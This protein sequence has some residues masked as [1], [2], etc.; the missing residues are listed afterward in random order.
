MKINFL[1]LLLFSHFFGFSQNYFIY[2]SDKPA[3]D[4]TLIINNLSQKSLERRA[5]KNIKLNESDFPINQ[6]YLD[7]L[8]EL[9][10]KP[11]NQSKWL[12]GVL[13]K[14]SDTNLVNQL[15]NKSYVKSIHNLQKTALAGGITEWTS[16][17]YGQNWKST[18]FLGVEKLHQQNLLGSGILIAIFDAGFVSVNSASAFGHLYT[19]NLLKDVYNFNNSTAEIYQSSNHGTRVLSLINSK[20]ENS[21]IGT[22]P[23]SE[24]ALYVTENINSET[25]LEEYQWLF[26]AERADSLG[27]DIINSS[28]GYYDFDFPSTNHTFTQLDG[29]TTVISKAAKIASQKG[30]LVV[31]STGNSYTTTIWP[32]INFPAD[33]EEVL[34]VG[35][36]GFNGVV[37][38]FSSRGPINNTYFKP[39]LVA[40]GE[41]ISVLSVDN[42]INT[43]SGSSF[44][45]PLIAG[46]S[47]LIWQKNPNFSSQ[48][49]KKYLIE[50]GSNFLNPNQNIGYGYPLTNKILN[51]ED[52]TSVKKPVKTSF[53]DVSG[54]YLEQLPTVQGLYI[55]VIEY[56]NGEVEKTKIFQF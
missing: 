44:S 52:E 56:E 38:D 50:N 42:Q 17:N 47:A 30:I 31:N 37:S 21:F 2:F 55:Q 24:I 45:A 25:I 22:A 14:V 41:S 27:V 18:S 9:G 40:L 33:V 8:K 5:N 26:A 53:F 23:A 51:L 34:T 35:S 4:T 16:S 7:S 48:E 15:K 1:Y 6:S 11:L 54:R 32:Y 19:E 39:E 46:Y 43:S 28:L 13:I 10:I 29:N 36:I 3:F 12:N 49:L 20:L